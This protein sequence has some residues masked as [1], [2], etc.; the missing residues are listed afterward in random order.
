MTDRN[1][2]DAE[3]EVVAPRYEWRIRFW[4]SVLFWGYLT[5][6]VG[7]AQRML[8]REDAGNVAVVV[9]IAALVSPTI[10]CFRAV[11]SALTGGNL[12]DEQQA[13]IERQNRLDRAV[14]RL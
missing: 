1:V 13:Q 3:F 14:S 5:A 8:P 6:I 10:N 2:T 11:I 12:I 4:P 9:L 7:M